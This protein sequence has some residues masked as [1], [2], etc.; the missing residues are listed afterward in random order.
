MRTLTRLFI[1]TLILFSAAWVAARSVTVTVGQPTSAAP[2]LTCQDWVSQTSINDWWSGT[3]GYPL[4]QKIKVSASTEVCE[5]QIYLHASNTATGVTIEFWSNAA[6]DATQYGGASGAIASPTANAWNTFTWSSNAPTLPGDAYL[7]VRY[8]GGSP[9]WSAHTTGDIY[10]A[11]YRGY[12][13]GS[14]ITD[15]EDGMCFAFRI[16]SM[17]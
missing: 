6:G 13:G 16:D 2:E 15:G 17:Q 1:A 14:A 10:E 8:S 9:Y 11:G 7:V 4:A 12:A 5:V 3:S